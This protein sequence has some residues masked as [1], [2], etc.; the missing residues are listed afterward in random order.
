[1]PLRSECYELKAFR[2]GTEPPNWTVGSVVGGRCSGDVERESAR[3]GASTAG[4]DIDGD[5]WADMPGYRR[6]VVRPRLF[7]DRP[8]RSLF[9]TLG[10]TSENREG[11]AMTGAG[12]AAD[13]LSYLEALTTHRTMRES[14]NAWCSTNATS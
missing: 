5:G 14:P 2:F 1:V 4:N 9:A 6:A 13:G 12:G 7:F 3:L 11:G 8:G 10:V